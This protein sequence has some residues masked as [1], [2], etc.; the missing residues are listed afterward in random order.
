MAGTPRG[1]HSCGI[2]RAIGAPASHPGIENQTAAIGVPGEA[3]VSGWAPAQGTARRNQT[4]ALGSLWALA[5]PVLRNLT[6]RSLCPPHGSHA[7]SLVTFHPGEEPWP[8]AIGGPA[9]GSV[10]RKQAPC[11]WSMIAILPPCAFIYS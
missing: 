1:Q 10:T 11:F 9:P 3:A 2:R 5:A 7:P 6:A 4:R 8:I